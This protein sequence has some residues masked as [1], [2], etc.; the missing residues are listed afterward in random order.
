MANLNLA[1]PPPSSAPAN[2]APPPMYT[3]PTAGGVPSYGI[4]QQM[5]LPKV[6]SLI[7]I[8]DNPQ[9]L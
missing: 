6:C 1:P 3:I 2:T 5:P 7:R 8:V 9:P 4:P